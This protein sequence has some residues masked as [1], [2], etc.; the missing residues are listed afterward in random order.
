MKKLLFLYPIEEYMES[1]WRNWPETYN[2]LND[3][4]NSRYRSKGYQ[5]VFLT[6][7]GKPTFGL[8]VNERDKVI[9]TDITFLE[10]ITPIGKDNDGNDVYQYPSNDNIEKSLGDFEEL[11]VCGFHVQDCVM[12]V[13]AHFYKKN[14]STLVDEELTDFFRNLSKRFYFDKEKYNLANRLIYDKA[15]D[16]MMYGEEFMTS[17]PHYKERY[18]QPYFHTD[19]FKSDFTLEECISKLEDEETKMRK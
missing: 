5:I 17:L 1:L 3:T 6:F 8:D 10:H 13:A 4:I 16:M 2:L 14:K 19:G 9:E 11:V 15:E 7:K 12:K 18:C